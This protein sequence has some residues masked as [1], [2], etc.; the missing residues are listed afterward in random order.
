[1]FARLRKTKMERLIFTLF[2]LISW[3][4]VLGQELERPDSH[5]VKSNLLQNKRFS[6]VY[7]REA[8]EAK[9]EGTINIIFD[10]DPTCSFVNR[11]QDI[12]LGYGCDKVAQKGLD[13]LEKDYK[14]ENKY[15]CDPIKNMK[16]PFEFKLPQK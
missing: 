6:L 5:K 12:Q 9:V 11:S 4:T 14:R 1:M 8:V 2:L 13:E 7:P 10:I 15:T 16:L 3:T